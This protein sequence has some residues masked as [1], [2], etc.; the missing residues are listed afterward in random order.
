MSKPTLGSFCTIRPR[1]GCCVAALEAA[2]VARCGKKRWS[3]SPSLAGLPDLRPLNDAFRDDAARTE[4]LVPVVLALWDWAEW[5]AGRR[6][7]WARGVALRTIRQV[8]PIVLRARGLVAD[9]EACE[10]AETLDQ[11]R[12]AARDAAVAAAVV[13]A[14][15]AADAAAV[16]FAAASAAS[17]AFVSVVFAAAFAAAAADARHEVLALACRIWREEAERVMR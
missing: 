8:L 16:V 9:A 7:D 6:V 2:T 10:R 15:D 3:A 17:V 4:H 11:A 12:A 14:R 5:P 13:F 1:I